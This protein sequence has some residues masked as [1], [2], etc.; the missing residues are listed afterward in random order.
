[1]TTTETFFK[2][3]WFRC[4]SGTQVV[5]VIAMCY[6]L[7]RFWQRHS[8][9]ELR[10]VPATGTTHSDFELVLQMPSCSPFSG[11]RH[12]QPPASPLYR[13][14]NS[15]VGKRDFLIEFR[16]LHVLQFS[17]TLEA[18][19]FWQFRDTDTLL[20]V[21]VWGSAFWSPHNN[22]SWISIYL[23]HSFGWMDVWSQFYLGFSVGRSSS[24]LG[25]V[26]GPPSP[27]ASSRV[28]SSGIDPED[29][30]PRSPIRGFYKSG[31]Q[32][33]TK[34]Q[35]KGQIPSKFGLHLENFSILR[36]RH[37]MNQWFKWRQVWELPRN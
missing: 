37:W 4:G 26:F 31:K 17:A 35:I 1:M 29:Q 18:I 21:I 19:V 32:K 23:H 20:K 16:L 14:F 27:I 36:L 28:G 15:R 8:W 10:V 12:F 7:W 2:L 9:F 13:A 30:Y 22:R 6:H 24:F 5:I 3:F 33:G 25:S 11:Y 34:E